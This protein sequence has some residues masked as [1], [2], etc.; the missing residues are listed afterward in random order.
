MDQDHCPDSLKSLNDAV[1]FGVLIRGGS[2]WHPVE[3]AAKL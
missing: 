1:S 3:P 2:A